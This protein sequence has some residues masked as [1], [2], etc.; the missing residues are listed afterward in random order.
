MPTGEKTDPTFKGLDLR[1]AGSL[2]DDLCTAISKVEKMEREKVACISK[3]TWK[4]KDTMVLL[5]KM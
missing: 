1:Q 4:W 5:R 2:P 3:E